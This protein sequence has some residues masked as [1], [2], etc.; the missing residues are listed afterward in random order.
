MTDEQMDK[1][2]LAA[3][4][5]LEQI[6]KPEDRYEINRFLSNLNHENDIIIVRLVAKWR[7]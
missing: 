3:I 1:I 2:R 7:N 6:E 5:I 4:T